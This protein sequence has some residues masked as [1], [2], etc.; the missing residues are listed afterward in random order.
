M[1]VICHRSGGGLNSKAQEGK[2][3]KL[4]SS[5]LTL[6]SVAISHSAAS[7]NSSP[8]LESNATSSSGTVALHK[9]Y[10]GWLERC[11][12]AS[13]IADAVSLHGIG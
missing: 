4:P 3:G 8:P 7:S 2:G 10:K 6:K 5:R 9:H 12:N 1:T 13:R 11:T